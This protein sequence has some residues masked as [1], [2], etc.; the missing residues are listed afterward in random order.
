MGKKML[1]SGVV[2]G[3]GFRA[4]FWGG[5]TICEYVIGCISAVYYY[6][7]LIY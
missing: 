5:E 3:L 2:R 6:D 4:L 1:P 7:K